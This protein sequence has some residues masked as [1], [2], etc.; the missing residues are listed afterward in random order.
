MMHERMHEKTC[1]LAFAAFRAALEDE[2]DRKRRKS[3][4]PP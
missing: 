4:R 1:L 3:P 2:E